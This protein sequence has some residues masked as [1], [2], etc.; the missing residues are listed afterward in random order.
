MQPVTSPRFPFC[1]QKNNHVMFSITPGKPDTR[2]MRPVGLDTRKRVKFVSKSHNNSAYTALNLLRNRVGK[3]HPP[4]LGR[5]RAVE[6]EC[7]AF[8]KAVLKVPQ[9]MDSMAH[10]VD[11]PLIKDILPTM[12]KNRVPAFIEM[13]NQLAAIFSD[14][15]KKKFQEVI[16][17]IK[18]FDQ[19]TKFDNLNDYLHH[20]N[21]GKRLQVY[22]NFLTKNHVDPRMKFEQEGQLGFENEKVKDWDKLAVRDKCCLAHM[23]AL[24][25]VADMHGFSK[26]HW[27]PSVHIDIEVLIE[28]L[29]QYGPLV[30]LGSFGQ[31]HY[32][33]PP[34]EAKQTIEDRIQGCKRKI[35]YW[36]KNSPCK[37]ENSP[38]VAM[39]IIG[40]KTETIKGEKTELV[41]YIDPEDGSDPA[42]IENQ[43]IYMM[44]YRNLRE[45]IA[46]WRGIRNSSSGKGGWGYHPPQ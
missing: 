20:E 22:L 6:K 11:N 21:F 31:M 40:A 7:S 5:Q 37:E 44:S 24:E 43:K 17:W 36:P 19:Q 45:N 4:Q 35:F 27:N 13:I 15:D 18:K 42:Q 1:E 16:D 30:V 29:T 2:Q 3:I 23:Y 46:N 32:I 33:N 8:Q 12:T 26:T 28:Q 10:Q 39:I 34:T 41:Y 14:E 25:L 9:S 38:M